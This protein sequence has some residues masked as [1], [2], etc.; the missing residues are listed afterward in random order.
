MISTFTLSILKIHVYLN[1]P[2]NILKL[3]S[4]ATPGYLKPF[5]LEYYVVIVAFTPDL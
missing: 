5:L 2:Y 4:M 1:T 3:Y